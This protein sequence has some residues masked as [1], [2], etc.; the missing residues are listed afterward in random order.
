[1]VADI[2][3]QQL[4][5]CYKGTIRQ[6]PISTSKLGV[7][8]KNGSYQTP[9]GLHLIRAKIGAGADPLSVFQ[10][11]RETGELCTHEV[12]ARSPP[13]DWILGR[14]LW[15]SG[16]E[17]YFNRRGNVDTMRR[18]VYIHG[19]PPTN[20]IATP[21]SIGCLRMLPND[22]VALF[23]TIN[24]YDR[25]WIVDGIHRYAVVVR[26]LIPQKPNSTLELLVY[27]PMTIV[28]NPEKPCFNSHLS[29]L[30]K[31]CVGKAHAQW[32]G[33]K[34]AMT[35]ITIHLPSD[36][37][38][39]EEAFQEKLGGLNKDVDPQAITNDAPIP[40]LTE[41]LSPHG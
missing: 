11:R 31:N 33:E 20:D 3:T 5:H 23:D 26:H 16:L 34:W 29:H 24:P 14:I 18:F 30:E 35:A 1:M 2:A 17:P 25:L 27:P 13:R 10:R 6:Y 40:S 41:K 22:M 38:M 21:G 8:E 4:Y 32:T 39:I 37:V 19:T 7:G 15:L 9:R 12:F 36:K 28:P